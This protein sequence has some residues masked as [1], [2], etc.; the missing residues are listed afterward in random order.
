MTKRRDFFKE[1]F[2]HLQ[3]IKEEAKGNRHFKL[4]DLWNLD[5]VKF[6]EMK[7][8]IREGVAIHFGD[9]DIRGSKDEKET[10]FL[11]AK[12]SEQERMFQ[13]MQQR[14]TVGDIVKALAADGTSDDA[15]QFEKVRE[16]LLSLIKQTICVPAIHIH[17]EPVEED[18]K[19]TP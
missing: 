5:H 13:L 9:T 4:T 18:Q 7:F 2:S 12:G 17:Y 16:F 19:K 6:R 15:A 10:V 11:C 8:R 1:F 3:V 14:L